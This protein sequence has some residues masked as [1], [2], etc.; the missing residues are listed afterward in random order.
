MR[1]LCSAR[2]ARS[3]VCIAG[4]VYR[5]FVCRIPSRDFDSIRTHLNLCS[6]LI[7]LAPHARTVRNYTTQIIHISLSSAKLPAQTYKQCGFWRVFFLSIAALQ[8]QMSAIDWI[9]TLIKKKNSSFCC[10]SVWWCFSSFVSVCIFRRIALVCVFIEFMYWR[11]QFDVI[12][13]SVSSFILQW[14]VE[15]GTFSH[16]HFCAQ[17]AKAS[18]SVFVILFDIYLSDGI[19]TKH[20]LP[21]DECSNRNT[22][23]S[24]RFSVSVS[25]SYHKHFHQVFFSSEG[26]GSVQ[27]LLDSSKGFDKETFVCSMK[28]LFSDA[29]S[30]SIFL[31][32]VV[33]LKH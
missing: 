3:F 21:C 13:R 8:F 20:L 17:V 14:I 31:V 11:I 27:C 10:C 22:L 28:A 26:D 5:F 30:L 15:M 9:N 6:F 32:S 29:T 1:I 4:F 7:C 33:L 19:S 18:C 23:L 16:K 2:R 12:R 25:V 24:L